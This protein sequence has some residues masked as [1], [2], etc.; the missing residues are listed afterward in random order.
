MDAWYLRHTNAGH[1]KHYFVWTEKVSHSIYEVRTGWG[2]IGAAPVTKI[3]QRIVGANAATLA[4]EELVRRKVSR[5]YRL[6]WQKGPPGFSTW[7]EFCSH[8]VAP[9]AETNYKNTIVPSAWSTS[10]APAP[11]R[12]RKPKATVPEEKPKKEE[13]T[14]IKR[15]DADWNF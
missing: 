2:K 4:A 8:A 11:A 12:R 3:E 9:R 15:H 14:S 10:P 13:R 5:G 7:D 6:V 1:N